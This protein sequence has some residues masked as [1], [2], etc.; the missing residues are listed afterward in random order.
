VFQKDLADISEIDKSGSPWSRI[1]CRPK[2]SYPLTND[3]FSL[4]RQGVLVPLKKRREEK[5]PS[6]MD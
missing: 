2:A 3:S 1:Q 4:C 6:A 5:F